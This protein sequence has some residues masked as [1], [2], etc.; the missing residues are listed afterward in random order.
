MNQNKLKGTEV[1][2]VEKK[3][4]RER[5]R[6]RERVC[7]CECKCVTGCELRVSYECGKKSKQILTLKMNGVLITKIF[8]ILSGKLSAPTAKIFCPNGRE[9][10]EN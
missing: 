5:E 2:Q 4:A 8:Q 10:G 6:E 7:V 3:R 9:R 1:W